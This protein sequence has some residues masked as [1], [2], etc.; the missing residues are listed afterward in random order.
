MTV[1]ASDP[2]TIQPLVAGN[3]VIPQSSHRIPCNRGW[4][5]R[6]IHICSVAGSECIALVHFFHRTVPFSA[7]ASY[8]LEPFDNRGC[9]L[10]MPDGHHLEP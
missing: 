8:G 3:I 7:S 10:A 5:S 6:S 9:S 4:P 1:W 2:H